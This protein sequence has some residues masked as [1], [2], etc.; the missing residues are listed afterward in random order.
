[1][2][3]FQ[4]VYKQSTQVN[5]QQ[6]RIEFPNIQGE[7]LSA[8][9]SLP[10]QPEPRGYVLFAHCFTC[11]KNIAAA[12]RISRA[13][14]AH[15][16]AVLRFDFTGL[17]NSEGDFANT[18]FSSNVEDLLAA[19]DFLRASYQAPVMMIGHSLG[20][21]AVLAAAEKVPE[22]KAVCTIGAPATP[23][24]LLQNLE[25]DP[26]A[27]TPSYSLTVGQKTFPIQQQFVN[28]LTDAK[29][30]DKLSRLKRALLVLHA[31]LDNVVSIDEAGKIFQQAKHP[32]SFV[33]LDGADHLVSRAEDVEYVADVIS[34][35]AKRYI[36]TSRDD[37]KEALAKGQVL[38]GE[39]NKKF[40]RQVATDDHAWVADEPK[41]VGGDNL[42]PDPYEHLLAA[43]GTCTSMTIRMYANH[44]KIPL[45]DVDITLSH[46]REHNQDCE[47]CDEQTARLDVLSRSIKLT[48]NL[49]DAERARLLQIADRC[50]VHKTLEGDLQIRTELSE[51][52]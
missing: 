29:V 24:H 35:W 22:C 16:F 17:G 3:P 18:N 45:E 6:L 36:P 49:S 1:M 23:A 28:D 2:V 14:T 12:S 41:K 32:K 48:G 47:D 21:A 10:A 11:G 8:A 43:L 13:L 5:V 37:Q 38:V 26:A 25:N 39:A 7:Q 19:A 33:S 31:P 51:Q 40:L 20:G 44:K 27:A 30:S 9:L 4:K 34:A 42:G 46:S 50:P 15:G 52:S